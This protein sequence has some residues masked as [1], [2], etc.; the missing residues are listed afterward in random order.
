MGGHKGDKRF[1]LRWPKTII[2][3]GA[4]DPLYDDTLKI[5]ERMASSKIDCE[6][7]VYENLPH[8]FLNLEFI[9]PECLKTIKDSVTHLQKLLK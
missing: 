5:M 4:Q 6:C 8:G 1:P 2:Q 3:V 7:Q 9:I